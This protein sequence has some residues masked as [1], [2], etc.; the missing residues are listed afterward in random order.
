MVPGLF[1]SNAV[2]L[3]C[4]LAAM[5]WLYCCAMSLCH[6]ISILESANCGLSPPKQNQI[7]LFLWNCRC[8]VLCL[9]DEKAVLTLNI[10]QYWN[11]GMLN[12]RF[13]CSKVGS[14]HAN[15]KVPG[16]GASP[17]A[18]LC[19]VICRG[20]PVLR[21][22]VG[23]SSCTWHMEAFWSPTGCWLPILEKREPDIRRI[24]V[25]QGKLVI[26]MHRDLLDAPVRK[27]NPCSCHL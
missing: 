23:A 20:S 7:D 21:T 18:S 11:A 6:Q 26:F 22:W 14:N 16:C 27:K 24:T 2:S 19:L 5:K 4:F 8:Q 1:L 17:V 9:S 15:V 12:K 3:H 10:P 13:I 25:P